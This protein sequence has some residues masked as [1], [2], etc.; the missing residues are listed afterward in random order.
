MADRERETQY[1]ARIAR[2][3]NAIVEHARRWSTNALDWLSKLS[4]IFLFRRSICAVSGSAPC[5]ARRRLHHVRHRERGLLGAHHGGLRV[6]PREQ[7]ARI[8][9]ASA[10]AVVTAPN[11]APHI[12]V[13]CGTFALVTAWIIFEPCLIMPASSDALPTM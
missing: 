10:H 11:E 13:I 7:E 2:I 12:S 5:G 8:V 4:M 6:R 1:I 3:D 9:G